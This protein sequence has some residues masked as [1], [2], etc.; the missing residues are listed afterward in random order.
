M[1]AEPETAIS[2][3]M[4]SLRDIEIEKIDRNEANPRLHF[5]EDELDRLAQSISK[6]GILVPVVVYEDGDD[7][8]RL[9]DGER[10]W[11]CAQQLGLPTVPAVVIE[12]S[13][14]ARV[15]LVRMFNIHMVREPWKDMPTAWALEKLIEETG[16][17]SNRDL[18]DVTGL[19]GER[20]ERL[21]HALE[22]PQDYQRYID[23][24]R[25]PLN[26]F[27]ELKKSVIDP[28]ARRRPALW[29]EFGPSEVLDSFVTKRLNLVV[30]DAVS[31]RKVNSVIAIAAREVSE[32]TQYSVLDDTIRHLIRDENATIDEA[33][34]DTV[35]LVVESDKLER[36]TDNMVKSFQRLLERVRT[37]DERKH[38]IDVGRRLL[39]RLTELFQ[40]DRRE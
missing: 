3:G 24:G 20:I 39:D 10:R 1:S 11:L 37:A 29:A 7:H 28:L 17:S 23:E 40:G 15:N 2:G 27:W 4:K 32:P 30:T 13:P 6:E 5:P 21:R 16:I 25:I 8:F 36:R 18:S 34:Q 35:E 33:Y 38:V 22:L 26:F 12:A 9:V 14:D 31:L 19:S